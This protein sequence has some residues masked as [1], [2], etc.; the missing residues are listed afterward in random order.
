MPLDRYNRHLSHSV[1][2]YYRRQSSVPSGASA[3]TLSSASVSN[4]SFVPPCA[5]YPVYTLSS[6]AASNTAS[7]V[8]S[9][10]TNYCCS[11]YCDP[12]YS[13]AIPDFVNSPY[14]TPSTYVSP[15]SSIALPSSS[16]ITSISPT[17]FSP[18]SST[19]L[20]TAA[21]STTTTSTNTSSAV[22]VATNFANSVNSSSTTT[23]T[24]NSTIP[25]TFFA[26]NNLNTSSSTQASPMSSR[27]SSVAL[28]DRVS[29]YDSTSAISRHDALKSVL[30][31]PDIE[32]Y[33]PQVV[34]RAQLSVI[35]H[36]RK[37]NNRYTP[38][39]SSGLNERSMQDHLEMAEDVCKHY[40]PK[41]A[42]S[43]HLWN[44]PS[45]ADRVALRKKNTGIKFRDGFIKHARYPA[46]YKPCYNNL[47]EQYAI[48]RL[49]RDDQRYEKVC[50]FN[51]L[52]P[53]NT[54]SLNTPPLVDN[55]IKVV[56]FTLSITS[57]NDLYCLPSFPDLA[58]YT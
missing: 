10:N 55:P 15:A 8:P 47:Y 20:L 23:T 44:R 51:S 11:Y 37:I 29:H 12:S 26:T 21:S 32:L 54:S 34:N 52:I 49:G 46:S 41:P 33:P 6:A 27:E 5:A 18:A 13:Y 17:Y 3:H 35:R 25:S 31:S 53:L 39:I 40:I 28:G 48:E 22:P 43:L 14:F 45:R 38:Y 24:T 56:G 16:S 57:N 30:T 50:L 1:S 19:A 36:R 2:P 4:T 42:V 58:K 9:I 7:F